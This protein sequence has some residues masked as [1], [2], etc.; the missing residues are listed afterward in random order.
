MKK[1]EVTKPADAPAHSAKKVASPKRKLRDA[2]ASVFRLTHGRE[3]TDEERR[4]FGLA[5][6]NTDHSDRRH[7]TK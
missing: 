1:R 6:E 5:V 2:I 3:M 4:M 7:L